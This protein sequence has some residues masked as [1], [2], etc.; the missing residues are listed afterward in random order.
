M[1]SVGFIYWDPKPEI[2]IVPVIGWPVLWYGV[3]FALGFAL[4]FPLFVSV[5]RRYFLQ[6]PAFESDE[7]DAASVDEWNLKLQSGEPIA[8]ELSAKERKIASYSIR[9]EA[10]LRRLQ[11]EKKYPTAILSLKKKATVLTD[12]LT[13]YM[14]VATVIGARLGHFL[15]YEKP[16]DYLRNLS[17]LL[18]VWR[19]GL[20]SH[21]AAIGIVIALWIFAIRYRKIS[22]G[23]S[24]LRLLDF[25][26][27]PTALAGCLI[28]IGNFFNQE[29]LGKKT[30]VFWAVVFGHPAD[31]SAPAPRHPVQLY[32]AL[33]YLFIFVL[34]WKLS[35]RPKFLLVQGRLIGLFLTLIFGA[36]FLVEFWKLEQSHI[37]PLGLHLTMGQIL[38]VPAVAIGLFLLFW[39]RREEIS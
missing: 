9:K 24:L 38:S 26:S 37:M 14:V 31:R 23:L 5:L 17:E 36:R 6:R 16:S 29:I 4:G 3:L 8:E 10:A 18:Q 20:S 34:L 1:I 25:V 2:F 33:V 7:V 28:R 39:K 21:G 30:D 32:E 35:F 27:I 12:K 11:L 19:G 22:R 13:V 15:F